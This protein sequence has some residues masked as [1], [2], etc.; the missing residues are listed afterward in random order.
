MANIMLANEVEDDS[1]ESSKSVDG[2]GTT[3]DAGAVVVGGEEVA[4]DIVMDSSAAI[5]ST[6]I[7]DSV[8]GPKGQV[9]E[10]SVSIPPPVVEVVPQEGVQI[11]SMAI[12]HNVADSVPEQTAKVHTTI[13]AGVTKPHSLVNPAIVHPVFVAPADTA[14]PAKAQEDSGDST[15]APGESPQNIRV[16]SVPVLLD[17]INKILQSPP[18]EH[19]D[20][21]NP[22]PP[23]SN[24][25][26][27]PATIDNIASQHVDDVDTALIIADHANNPIH[28]ATPP[29]IKSPLTITS[30]WIA[31]AEAAKDM[32]AP[33]LKPVGLAVAAVGGV[34]SLVGVIWAWHKLRRFFVKEKD[35]TRRSMKRRHVRDWSGNNDV[36]ASGW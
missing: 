32:T 35:P 9:V 8:Q 33:I 10:E 2:E 21:I 29:V 28:I 24:N 14:P 36:V 15:F 16:N 18:S 13:E 27:V 34:A 1:T 26:L 12:P 25:R 30:P 11:T 23:S 19:L 5:K 20:T 3:E 7:V 6:D 4:Q 31:K 22:L 17:D